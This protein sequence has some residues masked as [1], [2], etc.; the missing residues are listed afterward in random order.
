MLVILSHLF[1]HHE[2]FSDA[3]FHTDIDN[4]CVG[5]PC[6]NGGTCYDQVGGVRCVCAIGFYGE[7]CEEGTVFIV[8]TYKYR[9]WSLKGAVC[10]RSR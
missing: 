3:S 4:G 6:R 10:K 1:I 2:R 9:C 8:L 5:K 7:T